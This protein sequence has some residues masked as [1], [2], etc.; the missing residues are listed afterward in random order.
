MHPQPVPGEPGRLRWIVPAGAL[1]C[2]GPMA[3]VPAPLEALLA[4]G[5]LSRIAVEPSAVVTDLTEGRSWSREGARVRTALHAALDDP[6]GWTP[7][8]ADDGSYADTAACAAARDVLAGPVGDFA[9]SHGGTIDLVDVRD[10]VVTVRLG[11][12]CHGCPAAWFTL[13]NR[14]ERELLRRLPGPLEIRSVSAPGFPGTG[15]TV[16]GPARGAD[17]HVG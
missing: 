9:R 3:A 1:P 11:G 13:H 4:D 16:P 8:A 17:R 12:A 10:G 7:A 15:R 2:A 6:A 5:T 14:L